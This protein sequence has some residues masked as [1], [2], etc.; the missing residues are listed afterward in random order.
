MGEENHL[1]ELDKRVR[2]LERK[3]LIYEQSFPMDR[4]SFENLLRARG[5]TEFSSSP[6]SLVK[7][8]SQQKLYKS[9]KSYY[10][11]RFLG[12]VLN[13]GSVDRSILSQLKKKWGR[14][15]NSFIETI[16]DTG[17]AE[18][19]KGT[20]YSRISVSNYG[21]ILQW[22]VS[23]F[24]KETYGS[25]SLID[26]KIRNFKDGGD[27]D[28]LSKFGLNLEMFECKSSPPNNIPVSE[29]QVILKRV[30]AIEPDLFALLIDTTLSI[31]RNIIDNLRWILHKEP[32][33]IREGIYKF[34]VGSYIIS[35]KRDLLKNVQFVIS[36]L[37]NLPLNTN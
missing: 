31:K 21:I 16:L 9:L 34:D 15:V 5:I 17:I 37:E 32:E 19:N 27:V 29:L 26:V 6:F 10:F 25:E 13:F 22:F 28:V 36:N 12:D 2:A 20:L 24:L 3:I 30:N 7:V 35:S 23:Q 11:R 8:S 4:F 1:I 33:R 14:Q 18:I